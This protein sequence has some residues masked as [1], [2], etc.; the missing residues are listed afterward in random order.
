MVTKDLQM[1]SYIRE[2]VHSTLSTEHKQ[3]V[4]A[5]II[6]YI[7]YV[8]AIT[9]FLRMN[10]IECNIYAPSSISENKKQKKH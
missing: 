7:S 10:I 6:Y 8:C 1:G 4:I 5:H 2:R 3:I 9:I